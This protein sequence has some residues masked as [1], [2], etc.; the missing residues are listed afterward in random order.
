MGKRGHK[1]VPVTTPKPL[2]PVVVFVVVTLDIPKD[3]AFAKRE[4]SIHLRNFLLLSRMSQNKFLALSV[5]SSCYD[6]SFWGYLW[7]ICL[8][9]NYEL[10]YIY[11][12]T[13]CLSLISS[14]NCKLIQSKNWAL[15]QKTAPFSNYCAEQISSKFHLRNGT[16]WNLERPETTYNEQE[17]T[18]SD[19]QQV[20]KKLQ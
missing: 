18:W 10:L 14:K 20:R 13:F 4:A 17:T 8:K 6:R 1:G 12:T 2:V 5:N 7:L 3:F 19:P 16:Y 11:L 15:N 9:H